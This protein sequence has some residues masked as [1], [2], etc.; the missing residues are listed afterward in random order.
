MS[1]SE[2]SWFVTLAAH[3]LGTV[4]FSVSILAWL[5]LT[6]IPL[7]KPELAE[8]I[9]VDKKARRRSAPAALQSHKR[10]SL[11]PSLA[12]PPSPGA[13]SPNISPVRTRRVYFLDSP[14]SSPSRPT[15]LIE[16]TTHDSSELLDKP[17]HCSPTSEISPSSSSSTLVHTYPA[18]PPQT[19]ETCRE[20]AIE[21][22]SSNSSPRSSL[23]LSRP[24]QKASERTR[25][26]SGT[27]VP[28]I[29]PIITV[30]T[31]D[32]KH[33]RSSI[34]FVPPWAFRRASGAKN[35]TS[36]SPATWPLD[37]RSGAV[38]FSRKTSRRVSTPVPRT[39]PYAHPYYAQP[40]VEDEAYA[41]HL[42]SLPQFGAEA[43][44]RSPTT[45]DSEKDKDSPL[46][47]QRGRNRKAN[48]RAQAALGLGR[49]PSL[50]PQRSASESW[51]A[52]QDPRL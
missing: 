22:D 11:A 21:S 27:S 3:G 35:S 36:A 51:A 19:L 2:R 41:A 20:S 24:F 47:D 26:M 7:P 8:P 23:S 32:T 49:R 52:G 29:A 10:D 37:H 16:R 28:E 25:R 5:W 44:S 6:L 40:P 30:P 12:R 31:S 42:R 39:Q 45:S 9:V 15:N 46:L 1:T 38:V 48:D 50:P 13:Q 4:G 34:G 43:V 18:I 17:L 33:R 14:T